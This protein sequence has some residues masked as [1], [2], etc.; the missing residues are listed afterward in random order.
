MKGSF[1]FKANEKNDNLLQKLAL[2]IYYCFSVCVLT[3]LRSA[4]DPML[5]FE[6]FCQQPQAWLSIRF[7]YYF[8]SMNFA[9]AHFICLFFVVVVV[10]MFFLF[11]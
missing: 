5:V 10:L 1:F 6:S 11:Q 8:F 2:N 9:F 7:V 3:V 4:G